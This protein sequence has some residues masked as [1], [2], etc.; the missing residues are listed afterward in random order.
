M[1]VL[2]RSNAMAQERPEGAWQIRVYHRKSA[3]KRDARYLIKCGC[4][5]Q[6]FEIYYGGDTLEIGG[7]TRSANSDHQ[8][9]GGDSQRTETL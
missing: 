6:N 1:K 9:P 3:G 2:K 8:R 5:D 7:V 4:C